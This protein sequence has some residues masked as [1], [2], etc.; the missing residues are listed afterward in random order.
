MFDVNEIHLSFLAHQRH[1]Q[2]STLAPSGAG[3]DRASDQRQIRTFWRCDQV[4]SAS[5]G[6]GHEVSA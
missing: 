1:G 2:E 6:I 4:W 3:G 5:N